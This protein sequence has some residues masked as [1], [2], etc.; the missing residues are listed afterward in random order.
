MTSDV[1]MIFTRLDEL[2]LLGCEIRSRRPKH[3]QAVS[4]SAFALFTA[5][6][7]VG[8]EHLVP[9]QLPLF[10]QVSDRKLTDHVTLESCRCSFGGAKLET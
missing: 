4:S 6:V 7:Q 8:F 2:M 5:H 3:R 10:V 9:L 1:R